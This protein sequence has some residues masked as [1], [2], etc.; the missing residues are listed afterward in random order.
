MKKHIIINSICIAL[1]GLAV[2]LVVKTNNIQ[3]AMISEQAGL[4]VQIAETLRD[5]HELNKLQHAPVPE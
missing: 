4:T 2:I 1:V 5:M 3:T